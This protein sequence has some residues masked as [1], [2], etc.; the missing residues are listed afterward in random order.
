VV[1]AVAEVVGAIAGVVGAIA[2]DDVVDT[3]RIY[4]SSVVVAV[5]LLTPVVQVILPT[6]NERTIRLGHGVGD[7]DHLARLGSCTHTPTWHATID[8]TW[9]VVYQGVCLR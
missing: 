1:R 2:D 3:N 5:K 8:E 4:A 9:S 7:D 6:M